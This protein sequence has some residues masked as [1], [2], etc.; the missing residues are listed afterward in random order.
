MTARANLDPLRLRTDSGQQGEGRAEL[1]GEVMHAEISP[2][3]AEFLGS[4]GQI[5]RLQA[6]RRKPIAS[7]TAAKES[8]GQMT[9]S[10]SFSWIG[11]PGMGSASRSSNRKHKSGTG[12]VSEVPKR[13]PIQTL[14]RP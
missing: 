1:A 14:S 9:E 7:A 3:R 6:G 12:R 4:D 2:V 10:R 8:N 11:S 5:D 13:W